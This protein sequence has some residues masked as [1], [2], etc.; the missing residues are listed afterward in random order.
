MSNLCSFGDFHEKIS[1]E[2]FLTR[3][4]NVYRL[5]CGTRARGSMALL[6]RRHITLKFQL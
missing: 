5:L 6:G 1:G 3:A 2:G 4:L